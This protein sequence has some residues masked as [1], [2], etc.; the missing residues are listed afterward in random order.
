MISP[1]RASPALDAG[2]DRGDLYPQL[3]AGMA[4]IALHAVL[5]RWSDSDGAEDPMTLLDRAFAQIG[6]A[7]A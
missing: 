7:L 6:P 3:A 1:R 4:L 2:G 5:Q